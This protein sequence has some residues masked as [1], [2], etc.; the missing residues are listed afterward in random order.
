LTRHGLTPG[1]LYKHLLDSLREAQLDGT[2]RTVRQALELVDRLLASGNE[3][4]LASG[5]TEPET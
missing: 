5:P 2:V 1:P 4:S 3:P